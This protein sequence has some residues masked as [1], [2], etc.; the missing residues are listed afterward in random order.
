MCRHTKK[1][2]HSLVG[3]ELSLNWP[4]GGHF[5]ANTKVLR[6]AQHKLARRGD[7]D[8]L[9]RLALI[10]LG[11][12]FF[13]TFS[14]YMATILAEDI[15]LAQ[16]GL[17]LLVVE[18][19]K[20]IDQLTSR[21]PLSPAAA[22][23]LLKI[24][25]ELAFLIATAPKSR[26]IPETS[27]IQLIQMEQQAT[28]DRSLTWSE[29]LQ[30]LRQA[31]IDCRAISN[32]SPDSELLE[33][34]VQRL[35][36]AQLAGEIQGAP[37]HQP[38]IWAALGSSPVVEALHWLSYQRTAMGKV[39]PVPRSG[40]STHLTL[41]MALWVL[42]LR[43]EQTPA[44]PVSM[45]HDTPT[46][47]EQWFV[48]HSTWV[49]PD[50]AYD[51]HT[52]H[53][54]HEGYEQ[55]YKEGLW[56]PERQQFLP[57]L[58]HQRRQRAY[59]LRLELEAVKVNASKSK[60][61]RARIR[62]G[63]SRKRSHEEKAAAVPTLSVKRPAKAKV[64]LLLDRP[65]FQQ[66]T[67]THKKPVY[68]DETGRFVLKGPYHPDQDE[69]RFQ[70]NLNMAR[71]VLE[72]DEARGIPGT[73]LDVPLPVYL[74]Q[75]RFLRWPNVAG[76]TD[77]NL[78]G[79]RVSNAV[80]E[81]ACVLRRKQGQVAR[82]VSDLNRI[83]LTRDILLGTLNHLYVRALLGIGDSGPH[84]VLV[85]PHTQRVY[86]IDL[87]ERRSSVG[88]ESWNKFLAGKHL[89]PLEMYH[90]LVQSITPL[91]EEA[92]RRLLQPEELERWQIFQQWL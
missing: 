22:Q 60:H 92:A 6:S 90:P 20:K 31:I 4:L 38:E 35:L 77:P 69:V 67:S 27:T 73:V 16:P 26:L 66:L 44:P 28:F 70:L 75:G 71:R 2:S 24:H 48:S 30:R 47:V 58:E 23:A 59:Q 9:Q 79:D 13:T 7:V 78:P 5:Q 63:S 83:E 80:M 76:Y 82:R 61:I 57:A 39:R 88:T 65:I 87:E 25:L 45:D 56:V 72:L 91:P 36:A 62:T 34:A 19:L 17:A 11:A 54:R 86:G 12:G 14:D 3:K 33:K 85:D 81:E 43:L 84:N 15:G 74:P 21:L 52:G 50:F 51:K 10:F 32:L 8:E 49:V 64:S 40:V 46:R 37:V 68:L 89:S 42:C 1:L 53:A 55:F 18:R 29:H 41:H